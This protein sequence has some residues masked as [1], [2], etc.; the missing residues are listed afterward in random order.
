MLT[1]V[2]NKMGSLNLKKGDR[3]DQ[4][5]LPWDSSSNKVKLG[6]FTHFSDDVRR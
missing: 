3:S 5:A 2:V 1:F 4:L 6:Q